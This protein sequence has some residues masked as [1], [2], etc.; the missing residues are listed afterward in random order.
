VRALAGALSVDSN[1]GNSQL[2]SLALGLGN[3]GSSDGTFVNAPIRGGSAT[4][5]GNK[6]VHL[7]QV[8]SQKLW[9]AIRHD[10]VAAFAKRY[11]ST[12]TSTAPA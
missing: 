12:V 9:Q 1:L 11:P 2:V 6:P 3:L 10:N 8:L 4:H 7:N 5:G